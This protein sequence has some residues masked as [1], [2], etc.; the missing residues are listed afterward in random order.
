M[1]KK[2]LAVAALG[3][4]IA[5]SAQADFSNPGFES[6]LAGWAASG[7]VSVVNSFIFGSETI[8]APEG[9]SMAL[10]GSNSALDFNVLL[11]AASASSQ[12]MT[13]WYR[14]LGDGDDG[15]NLE[16][17]QS[18]LGSGSPFTVYNASFAGSAFDT[19]WMRHTLLPG[20]TYVGF[21]HDSIFGSS[22]VLVDIAPVPE[23]GAY[24]MLLAGL[25]IMG[26]VIRRRSRNPRA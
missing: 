18:T 13:L 12:P 22:N 9:T 24:A 14:F 10:L 7:Q 11:Q 4:G 19:G 20:T 26:T 17:Q 25:G 6:G 16:V 23:P 21:F 15:V 1:I 5:T 8:F 2:A 3:L